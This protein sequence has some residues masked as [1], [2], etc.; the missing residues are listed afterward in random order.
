MSSIKGIG[1]LCQVLMEQDRVIH[2][3]IQRKRLKVKKVVI[4]GIGEID[5]E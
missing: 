1:K 3:V 5:G 2:L 4:V